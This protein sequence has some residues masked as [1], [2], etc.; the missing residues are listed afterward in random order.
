MDLAF[1]SFRSLG[2]LR[3]H[4]SSDMFRPPDERRLAWAR[5]QPETAVNRFWIGPLWCLDRAMPIEQ[6]PALP[7]CL[8]ASLQ[9]ANPWPPVQTTVYRHIGDL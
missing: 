2:I 3:R 8:R 9:L 4:P 1:Q 6:P 7:P 5:I